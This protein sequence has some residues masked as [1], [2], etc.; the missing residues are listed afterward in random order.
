MEACIIT[1]AVS[2][3]QMS[4]KSPEYGTATIQAAIDGVKDAGMP[5]TFGN[6]EQQFMTYPTST[7]KDYNMQIGVRVYNLTGKRVS[8]YTK[9]AQYY[10]SYRRQMVSNYM[11]AK[12]LDGAGTSSVDSFANW[13]SAG[14]MLRFEEYVSGF[15][16]EHRVGPESKQFIFITD[17]VTMDESRCVQNLPYGDFLALGIRPSSRHRKHGSEFASLCARARS[18]VCCCSA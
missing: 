14:E 2:S 17:D 9:G 7:A 11:L 15:V 18:L 5:V 16:M 3:S 12:T 4:G 1:L 13:F 6:I 8:I 10:D